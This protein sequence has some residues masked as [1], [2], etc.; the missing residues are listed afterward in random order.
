[1]A[2][3]NT[4]NPFD[5]NEE[6]TRRS[7][8]PPMAKAKVVQARPHDPDDP[9]QQAYHTA[10]VRVYGESSTFLAPILT[11]MAGDAHVPPVGSD[12][13]VMY[14]PNEK[15]WII[16]YWYPVNEDRE[17][18]EY[19]PGERVIGSPLSD[20]YMKIAADG[21]V[22]II[23]EGRARVD[24]DHQSASVERTG[25][26]QSIPANAI[27]KIQFN[28]IEEDP[29]ELWDQSNYQMVIRSDGLHRI[30]ASVALPTPGQNRSYSIYVYKN[31]SPIKR[32]T[33]QSAVNEEMSL[34]VLTM[35]RLNE[36]DKI[37]IRV[38]NRSN[39]ARNILGSDQTT[40][41]DIR[42]AGI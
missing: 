8:A 42:R 15:P 36:G 10:R 35:E 41:F 16:G 17:P 22:E 23:T 1:M 7:V 20:S 32:V 19:L 24:I 3:D 31:G 12:V 9:Q 4:M 33:R 37:D 28:N 39:S 25:S 26:D 27:T 34:S 11:S 5:Q 2:K 38:N 40:E 14:G 13:A 18:P 6:Q 29:E 21:H 30:N